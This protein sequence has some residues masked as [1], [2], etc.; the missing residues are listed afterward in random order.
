[1][2]LSNSNWI[3]VSDFALKILEIGS[4]CRLTEIDVALSPDPNCFMFKLKVLFNLLLFLTSWVLINLVS[5]C[6][7]A[8]RN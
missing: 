1:M 3:F 2:L 6:I 7:F 4:G 8:N 5:F